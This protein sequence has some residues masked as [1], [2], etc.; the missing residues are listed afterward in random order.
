MSEM[1]PNILRRSC[2]LSFIVVMLIVAGC[3]KPKFTM[4]YSEEMPEKLKEI[5]Q[6]YQDGNTKKVCKES[7][8]WIKE[9][10]GSNHLEIALKVYADALY[11]RE[12][13]Y[14][15]YLKYEELLN[16]FGATKYFVHVIDREIEIGK[17]FLAGQKR[18]FWKIFRVTARLEGL[19]ILDDIDSRWPG[20]KAAAKAVMLRADHFFYNKKYFEAEQE[21]HRVV[22]SYNRSCHYPRALFQLAESK[23]AQ[24]QGCVY[25]G[26]CLD[27]AAVHYQQYQLRFPESAKEKKVA[28]TLEWIKLEKVKKEYEIADFYYRT[29]KQ[30]Q[31]IIYWEHVF[32]MAPE[33]EYGQDAAVKLQQI[34][35]QSSNPS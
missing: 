35:E 27:E 25:D 31:A 12:K 23:K 9:N 24:Y 4:D 19:K 13:Y 3:S 8:K 14:V 21:Y 15:A 7:A 1:L 5:Q 26:V 34:E 2:L 32:E 28:E 22:N 18:T 17:L 20:S 16:Q 30:K 33:T 29:G 10:P 6:L 11:D